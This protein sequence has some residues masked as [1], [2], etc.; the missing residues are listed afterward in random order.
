MMA[1]TIVEANE[2]SPKPL[3]ACSANVTPLLTATGGGWMKYEIW[4]TTKIQSTTAA[5]QSIIRCSVRPTVDV[6]FN[7]GRLGSRGSVCRKASE[8]APSV[9]ESRK[10]KKSRR[11]GNDPSGSHAEM[12]S[13]VQRMTGSA[14]P[15]KMMSMT[16]RGT[17]SRAPLIND[18]ALGDEIDRGASAAS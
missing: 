7:P 10:R 8:L 15:S 14:F 18:R 1:P 4:S 6:R 2:S 3:R 17:E 9:I 13:V 12:R 5:L 11:G 16:T